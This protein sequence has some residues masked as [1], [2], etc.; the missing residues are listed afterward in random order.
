[1]KRIELKDKIGGFAERDA[2]SKAILN[3]DT[4]AL[5][6]YKMQK[7]RHQQSTQEVNKMKNEICS[8]RDDLCEIKKLLLAI[9]NKV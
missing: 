4:N 1:M 2:H 9:T 8:L 7:E 6:K 3:T 5:L